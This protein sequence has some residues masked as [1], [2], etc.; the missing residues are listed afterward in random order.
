MFARRARTRR[1]RVRRA[2]RPVAAL[3]AAAPMGA[4]I[5]LAAACGTASSPAGGA[6]PRPTPTGPAPG[7]SVPRPRPPVAT[8]PAPAPAAPDKTDCAGWPLASG[9]TL[10]LSFV[11]VAVL[12]CV[13]GD[14]MVPGKG[15]WLTATLERADNQNLMPLARA[16]RSAPGHMRPGRACPE[17]VTIPPPIALI[18]P[19]GTV[20]RPRFPVTSCGQIQQQV[21]ATLAALRW[22]TISQRLIAKSPAPPSP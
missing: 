16:L 14:T 20:I 1:A 3:V 8:V 13:T 2:E 4:L 9:G 17:F 19:D 22:H 15:E 21:T 12:R 5:V 10:P 11:P 7:V 18:G 6:G